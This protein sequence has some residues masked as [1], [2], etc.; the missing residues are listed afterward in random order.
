MS[1]SGELQKLELDTDG[2][3]IEILS[4]AARDR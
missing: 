1:V 2:Y 3:V 4:R